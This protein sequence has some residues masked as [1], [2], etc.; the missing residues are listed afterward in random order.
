MT[1]RRRLRCCARRSSKCRCSLRTSAT[2]TRNRATQL[3]GG[4]EDARA[5]TAECL[6]LEGDHAVIAYRGETRKALPIGN[7]RRALARR[8]CGEN[9]VGIA[10]DHSLGVDER[11]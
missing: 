5:E 9:D 8:R 3:L 7:P 4:V 11:A 1:C 2:D 10:C 6:V